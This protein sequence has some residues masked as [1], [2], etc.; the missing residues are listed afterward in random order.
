MHVDQRLTL[1]RLFND[2]FIFLKVIHRRSRKFING[3]S[4]FFRFRLL[5][6][7]VT[8]NVKFDIAYE[9]ICRSHF[10]VLLLASYVVGY[11]PPLSVTSP[12]FFHNLPSVVKLNGRRTVVSTELTMPPPL[13][14]ATTYKAWAVASMGFFVKDP[15]R[16]VQRVLG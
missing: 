1:C 4:P 8:I 9:P 13:D 14:I 5:I 7:Y 10:F 15:R 2:F 6:G 12:Y 3:C 16:H 11:R